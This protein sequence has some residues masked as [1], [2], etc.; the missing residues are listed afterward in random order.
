MRAVYFKDGEVE[1]RET[2]EPSGEGVRVHVRS[3]GVCGSDLHMLEMKSP[4]QCIVGHEVAGLLDDG[5]PVAVDPSVPCGE[6]DSCRAGDYNLCPVGAGKSL[7]VG[8]DGGMADELAVPDGC[9]VYL[10]SNV[11]VRDA[12]LVEPLAV[13][14]HGIH[15]AGL[16]A[17][18]RVAVVGG[19]TIGLC[20]V[21]AAKAG[22]ATVGLSARYDHQVAAGKSL[23]AGDVEGQYD[24]VVECAGTEKAVNRAIKLCRPKGKILILGTH[25]NGLLLQ[26]IPA[27]MK[28]ITIISSFV[29]GSN[30]GV[31]DCDVAAMLLSR[32][33]GIAK[34]LITHR[35]P[36]A[37]VKQAFAVARDRK[38]GAIKVVL[39][40]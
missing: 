23:G 38:A 9:L 40:P 20:A 5:T 1:L 11:D 22:N 25:W 3:I 35:F 16:E 19:G 39:E 34:A 31:R 8:R 29:S 13:A 10:P 26:Q 6:C 28:E 17:G 2:P 21:A 37:E 27:M 14:V 18:Q 33:P 15:R 12:C 4:L 32:H 7:G 24:L 36:L 30:G